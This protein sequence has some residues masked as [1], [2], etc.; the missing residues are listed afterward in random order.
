M[1][2]A[3]VKGLF[4]SSATILLAGGA[5][6][7]PLQ[8][9]R[10]NTLVT[11]DSAT[12]ATAVSTVAVS[13]LG[14]GQTLTGI[15]YRPANPRLLYGISNTG[16]LYV[17]N[18]RTGQATAV[19]TAIAAAATP[20]G[21]AV[22]FD[23][24]PTVDRIRF[25]TSTGVDLRLNP[26]TGALAA[27]DGAPAYAGLDPNAGQV[28]TVAG[29]GYT[30]NVA[31]A[32][33]T[34]LYEIDTRNGVAAARLVTQ[35]NANVSPN[36]GVLF[37]VG[38]TGVTSTGA[39]GLDVAANG[40]TYATLT[41]PTT[42]VTSLYTLNLSTGVATLVGALT[43]N[44][45]Y[46]GLAVALA[47]F[48]SMG[49][50]A[51]QAAVGNILDRFTG[52]PS[53]DLLNLF[54]GIDSFTGQTATQSALLQ[55]L[56]PAGFSD[57][58]LM[59]LN[60]VESQETTLLRYAR[61][62][63]GQ[64]TMPDGTTATLD[65]AGR[66]GAWLTGG[67]RFGITDPATDRYRTQFDEVHVMGGIDFRLS[68]KIAFGGF[69][70]YS[71]T[72]AS[73]AIGDMSKGELDSWFAGGY[74]TVGV[75]PF[76]VDGWGSY[77][78]LDWHLN[79]AISFGAPYASNT[80]ARTNGRVWAAGAATG[81][82]FSFKNFEIEPY[83]AIRFAD[84]KIDAFAETGPAV[85]ALAVGDIEDKSL[86][87]NLGNRVGTKFEI[88]GATVRPQV[89]GGWYHD[90]WPGR[91]P[92]T[93]A[94]ESAGISSTAFGFQPTR[95]SGDYWNAGGTLSISGNGP[96]SMYSDVDWQGDNERKFY[97]FSIGVRLAL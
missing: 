73:F 33:S 63:R 45:T 41:S 79:R 92:I 8:V 60:A 27:T 37:T 85:F 58:P 22:G 49:A 35:G 24:N 6:A 1:A 43:G 87:L 18:G 72:N 21:A 26:I 34:T 11:V 47:S 31:G 65:Q 20:A 19:G 14:T 95:F 80:A 15:D 81:L 53:A 96:L 66:L 36:T 32:T 50:T 7:A 51:N 86:R 76:Y 59:S 12:P 82:S 2:S 64:A 38:S 17:M 77:T 29:S 61:D 3:I 71:R 54:A 10:N 30:N 42:G 75:G 46:S 88:A 28:P 9:L 40:T 4:A 84:I 55:S 91:R 25:V 68:P 83:A 57:L 44:T 52:V 70:G 48:Q 69:G 78:D 94:F 56:S 90:F 74:Y 16:Q 39:V 93:A 62:L 5:T 89:R 67:S 13:G 97:T 23:F